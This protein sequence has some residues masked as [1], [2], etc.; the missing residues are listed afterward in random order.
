MTYV[1]SNGATS[2]VRE[3]SKYHEAPLGVQNTTEQQV[4]WQSQRKTTADLP[5]VRPVNFRPGNQCYGFRINSTAFC[6]RSYKYLG[7]SMID[8]TGIS[9]SDFERSKSFYVNALAPLGASLLHVIPPEHTDG[10]Q[11]VG[12]G[13]DSPCFW[14]DE[15][16]AQ[17]PPV[18]VA[19]K[20]ESRN[21]VDAFYLAALNAGGTDNGEPGIRKQYHDNYYGAFVL[22][23]DGNNI[24]VVCHQPE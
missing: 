2:F 6:F 12:F 24:E 3:I 16:H 21:V 15:G 1:N 23:P 5:L 19:F 4:K 8:H 20:A 10:V 14:I 11:V 18:H 22:D 17:W 9:V 13:I 7:A